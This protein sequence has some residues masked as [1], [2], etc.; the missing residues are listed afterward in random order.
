MKVR[1]LL[2]LMSLAVQMAVAEVPLKNVYPIITSPDDITDRMEVYVV[3]DYTV[4]AE[5]DGAGA[6]FGQLFV[7]YYSGALRAYAADD[8]SP[9]K[10]CLY[11]YDAESSHVL[12]SYSGTNKY[13]FKSGGTLAIEKVENIES[14]FDSDGNPDFAILEKRGW[15][16]VPDEYGKLRITEDATGSFL[17]FWYNGESNFSIGYNPAGDVQT[18]P[19]YL[20]KTEKVQI[21]AR[22]PVIRLDSNGIVESIDGLEG[23]DIYYRMRPVAVTQSVYNRAAPDSPDWKVW[24]RSEWLN[25]LAAI[26]SDQ[27]FDA[28]YVAG[29]HESE[30][31]S[32]A[33]H[34]GVITGMAESLTDGAVSSTEYFDLTGRPVAASEARG[35]VIVRTGSEYSKAVIND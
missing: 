14:A 32:V 24:N 27:M 35:L 21:I 29:E 17:D 30:V 15:I 33:M 7:T 26:T 31:S 25:S 13:F 10:F 12:P 5:A 34:A 4:T 1:S 22:K 20:A 28:K 18:F 9:A 16:L 2:L 19:A 8:K 3:S 11:L 23:A 6:S